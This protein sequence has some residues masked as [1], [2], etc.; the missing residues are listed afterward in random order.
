MVAESTVE[1]PAPT[2]KPA[3]GPSWDVLGLTRFAL[4]C[5]VVCTHAESPSSIAQGVAAFGGKAAVVAFLLISGYSIAASLA[6][7]REGFIHRRLLRIYPM[8]FGAVL[9]TLGVQIWAGPATYNGIEVAPSGAYQVTCNFAIAQMYLCKAMGF[10]GPLWSLGV[11]FSYYLLAPLFLLLPRPLIV[12]AVILSCVVYALPTGGDHGLAYTILTKFNGLK[13][14]WA[15]MIGFALFHQRKAAPLAAAL[16]VC[17]AVFPMNLGMYTGLMNL[18][19]I[20]GTILLLGFSHLIRLR[21][22]LK[23][24][25]YTLGDISYPL[26]LVHFPLGILLADAFGI[27]SDAVYVIGS[28]SLS[29]VFLIVF[30]HYFKTLAF[31]P[32]MKGVGRLRLARQGSLFAR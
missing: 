28:L 29:V 17:L 31:I 25:A 12:L 18:I 13:F 16:V 7:N 21:G 15:F 20:G 1:R 8:Y 6:K 24:L 5:I 26:Y 19:T 9:L 3:N 10:N 14:I 4:A 11:E 22:R 2:L 27:Q 30:D 23:R 32:L